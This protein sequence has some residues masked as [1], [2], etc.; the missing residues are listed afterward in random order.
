MEKKEKQAG[1]C[2]VVTGSSEELKVLKNG[3]ILV[4]CLPIHDQG[5]QA[6]AT[7]WGHIWVHRPTTAGV[8]A[9]IHDPC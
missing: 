8:Y 7:A 5:I 3:L 1:L 6:R 4:G 9:D 2:V